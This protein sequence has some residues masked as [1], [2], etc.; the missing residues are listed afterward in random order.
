MVGFG[1]NR[2]GARLPSF[3]PVA[4]MVVIVVLAYNYW[5]VSNKHG[6]LLD[7]LVEAQ[8]Q[9]QLRVAPSPVRLRAAYLS[10]F[11]L[12]LRLDQLVQQASRCLFDPEDGVTGG[13]RTIPGQLAYRLARERAE[14]VAEAVVELP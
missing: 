1:A 6:R 11:T 3:V 14:I 2:R 4:L 9:H 7:E 13:V 10:A 12:R 8:T 5:T